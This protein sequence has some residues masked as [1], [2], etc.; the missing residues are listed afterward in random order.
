[1]TTTDSREIAPTAIELLE[2][3]HSLTEL[4]RT[5]SDAHDDIG[6]LSDATIDALRS[7]HL[8]NF[9]APAALGGLELRPTQAL[10]VLEQLAYADGSAGWVAMVTNSLA[11]MLTYLEPDVARS[12]VDRSSAR[13]AGQGAPTGVA[14][15]VDNG[16]RIRGRWSYASGFH[17]AD[18]VMACCLCADQGGEIAY[19]SDGQPD[20]RIFLV[21][22]ADV[23]PLGNWDVLGLRGTGSIDYAINDVFIAAECGLDPRGRPKHGGPFAMIGFPCW[24]LLGHTAAALGIARHALDEAAA[25]ARTPRA[26]GGPASANDHTQAMYGR[27]EATLRA[28]RALVYEQWAELE[29][30]VD[31]GHALTTRRRTMLHLALLNATTAAEQVTAWSY[32]AGGGSAL[33]A[34]ALQRCVRDM[35]AATQHFLVGDSFYRYCG[36][37]LIGEA[38][39]KSWGLLGLI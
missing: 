37:D 33:R 9:C 15:A 30:D 35:H 5:Q 26:P 39:G 36:Q 20:V 22:V 14:T 21:P 8:F 7:A 25:I 18:H 11:M 29:A 28:A 17:V 6:R 19:G 27:I 31:A 13:I 3:A 34:G 23:E 1:M 38:Q 24:A 12:L 16:F 4:L 32:R 10:A 2:R